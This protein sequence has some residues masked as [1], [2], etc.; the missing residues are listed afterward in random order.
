MVG[1]PKLFKRSCWGT[2]LFARWFRGS[3]TFLTPQKSFPPQF[4]ALKMTTPLK[5][6]LQDHGVE[7]SK[8]TD[9]SIEF[10]NKKSLC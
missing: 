5:N 3:K 1:V 10:I 8:G 7:S 4:P 2:K 6:I 9:I